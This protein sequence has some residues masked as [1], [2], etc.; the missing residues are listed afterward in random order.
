MADKSG[1]SS[2]SSRFPKALCLERGYHW[3]VTKLLLTA[4]AL[5]LASLDATGALLAAGALGAGARVRAVLA[6]GCFC[7]LGTVDD[8][9][10][11]L[12]ELRD[13][14]A[15]QFN[16]YLMHDAMDETLDAYGREIMP[17]LKAESSGKA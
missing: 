1:V 16:V 13:L 17:A 6:F 9:K 14:G 2:R 5:G 11:K 8:H 10:K 12:G 3:R 15:D 7:I 4:F